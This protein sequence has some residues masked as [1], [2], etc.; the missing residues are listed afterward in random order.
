GL[1]LNYVKL[2]CK[3]HGGEIKVNS[4]LGIGS[5]FTIFIPKNHKS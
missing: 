3:L 1:G 4:E 2:I 5:E